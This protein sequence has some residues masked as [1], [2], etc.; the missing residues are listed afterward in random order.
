MDANFIEQVKANLLQQRKT[1]MSSLAERSDELKSLV[2]PVE[3]GDE[4]DVASDAVDR[5]L[6]DSMSAKDSQ[7]LKQIDNALE[8][9]NQNKYGIC[10]SC[11]NEIPQERLQSLPYTLMCV[12]CASAEER[13]KR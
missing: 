2:K 3:Q 6:I 13:R 12:S 9:I 10:V 11:G 7:L 1:I 8:R 5:R 4:A